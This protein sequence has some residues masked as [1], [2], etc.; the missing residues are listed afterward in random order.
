MNLPVPD[1]EVPIDI[2]V[3]SLVDSKLSDIRNQLKDNTVH[4]DVDSSKV[5]TVVLHLGIHE[6]DTTGDTVKNADSVY[7]DYEKLLNGI[8]DKYP[9]LSEYVISSVPLAKFGESPT[10]M[11]VKVNEQIALLNQ[12]LFDLSNTQQNIH[13][14]NNEDD[15]HIDPSLESLHAGPVTLNDK[16]RAI[17]ADNIR[18]SICDS[19]SRSMM[20]L[21][22]DRPDWLKKV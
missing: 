17:L 10:D 11:E 8:S 4:T 22:M 1:T 21:G 5:D 7:V 9:E 6:W 18:N 20:Q 3:C 12:K 15:L 14:I 13:F 16:G 19:I 2:H